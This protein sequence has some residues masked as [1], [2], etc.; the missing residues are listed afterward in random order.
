MNTLIFVY[1]S[2]YC[3]TFC[4]DYKR[5]VINARHELILIRARNG[6]NCIV[7]VMSHVALNEVNKLSMVRALESG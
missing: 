1:R 4:E 7:R 3:W 6:N 5:V 2:G